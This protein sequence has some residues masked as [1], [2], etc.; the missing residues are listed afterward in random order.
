RVRLLVLRGRL[1]E[2]RESLRLRLGLPQADHLLVG[3]IGQDGD[4]EDEVETW[5]RGGESAGGDHGGQAAL[6]VAGVSH[7]R[8]GLTR[9]S[10][11]AGA[12]TNSLT[13]APSFLKTWMRLWL[14]SQT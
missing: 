9:G 10:R 11:V 12:T 1:I 8:R 14:R 5:Q 4:G 13:K 7:R 2:H 6:P 3:R